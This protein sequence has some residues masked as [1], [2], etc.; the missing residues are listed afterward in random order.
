MREIRL[1]HAADLHLDP[2]FAS[3][4]PEAA[5][6]RR[7]ERRSLLFTLAE[8][9]VE[10]GASALLLSGDVFDGPAISGE[11]AEAFVRA[12]GGL[13]IPVLAVTGNHDPYTPQ[14]P[15][16]LMT[17]PENFYLFNKNEF[18]S[19]ELPQLGVR[20]WGAGFER[21]FAPPL[22]RGFS[23]PE[24]REGLFEVM[25]LHG[26]LGFGASD[27]CPVTRKELE[28]SGMDYVAMG[29]IHTRSPLERAGKTAFAYPGCIEGGGFDETGEKGALL[30]TLS[31]KGVYTEF[32]PLGGVRYE[33]VRADVTD[34]DPERA[35]IEAIEGLSGRDRARVIFTGERAQAPSLPELKRTLE[36]SLA[37]VQLRD[38][39]RRPLD[40]W[41]AMGSDSLEGL[42]LEK[43][44]KRLE[45]SADERERRRTELAAIYGLK[46]LE[47][48]G[49][50]L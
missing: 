17:L 9:T 45:A 24:R 47:R 44:H 20:F 35:A 15:W 46:A 5:E 36:K 27:Y 13:R 38:E 49:T 28:E 50:V 42:F 11:T 41:A 22:L 6:R 25:L 7:R 16:A 26:D 8:K 12:V 21:T 23:A 14:S 18:T 10:K 37:E 30:V 29:H 19:L 40:I 43:L 39:T 2:P 33:I 31:E 48:G 32:V 34:T 4:P 1:M 3:L